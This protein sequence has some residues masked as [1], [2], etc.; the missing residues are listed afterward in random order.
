MMKTLLF[1]T[2]SLL[3][4]NVDFAANAGENYFGVWQGTVTEVST[5]G[6]KH[7]R[8]DVSVTVT[9]TDYRVD[10]GLLECGGVLRLL[11]HQGRFFRFRDELDYGLDKCDDGGRTEIHFLN[12]RQATFQWFDKNGVM[13]VEGRLTR[14]PQLM[15]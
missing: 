14:Q 15:I 2:L 9:P 8:Y 4:T 13:K 3:L 5:A 1:F 11:M 10:Y 6:K 7:D 12:P